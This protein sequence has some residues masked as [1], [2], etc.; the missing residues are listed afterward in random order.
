MKQPGVKSTPVRIPSELAADHVARIKA[1]GRFRSAQQAITALIED[2]ADLY[3]RAL[4]SRHT[5]LAGVVTTSTLP[6]RPPSAP[7]AEPP[8]SPAASSFDSIDP[9]QLDDF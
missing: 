6:R 5:V 4:E 3:C 9:A 1:A 2:C 8:Q 7:Q